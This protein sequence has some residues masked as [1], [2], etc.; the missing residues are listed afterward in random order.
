MQ[1]N[2]P[3]HLEYLKALGGPIRLS[4]M[5]DP[6]FRLQLDPS[7]WLSSALFPHR[8][9]TYEQGVNCGIFASEPRNMSIKYRLA[10]VTF[11]LRRFG[12]AI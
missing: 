3:R 5:R 6:S 8:T 2:V 9:A 12:G 10:V 11:Y 7:I 4:T 1:F